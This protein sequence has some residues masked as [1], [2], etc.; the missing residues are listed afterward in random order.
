MGSIEAESIL[1]ARRSQPRISQIRRRRTY[2]GGRFHRIV[3]MDN[4]PA[5]KVKIE[6]V[7]AG[8][9]Q[10]KENP[11][12]HLLNWSGP[13]QTGCITK[14]DTLDARDGLTRPP[15][16]SSFVSVLSRTRL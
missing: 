13:N 14:T 15:Q 1:S 7:Q 9:D 8:V 6:V 12:S 11:A 10:N 5:N 3:R 4:Q 2:D 16:I